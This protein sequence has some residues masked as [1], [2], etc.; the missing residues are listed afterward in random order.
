MFIPL[1]HDFLKSM[2]SRKRQWKSCYFQNQMSMLL[3]VICLMWFN[4]FKEAVYII[5]VVVN[6]SPIQDFYKSCKSAFYVTAHKRDV[7]NQTSNEQ[8]I[9]CNRYSSMQRFLNLKYQITS[10]SRLI[11]VFRFKEYMFLRGLIIGKS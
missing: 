6:V 8:L 4:S 5:L 7:S 10:R 9:P 3:L 2:M 11:V 1:L